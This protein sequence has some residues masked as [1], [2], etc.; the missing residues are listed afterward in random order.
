PVPRFACPACNAIMSAPDSAAGKKS[1]CPGCGQ[2]LQIPGAPARR[3]TVLG[4]LLPGRAPA[5]VPAHLA[6]APQDGPEEHHAPATPRRDGLV[7]CAVLLGGLAAVR[8]SS[9]PAS[10]SPAGTGRPR[11]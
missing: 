1:S 8:S 5:A 3:Q 2:R 4:H 7:A 10:P 11:S 6:T 9:S